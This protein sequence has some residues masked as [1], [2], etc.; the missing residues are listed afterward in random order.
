MLYFKN[1]ILKILFADL[2]LLVTRAQVAW[3]NNVAT[4]HA[5]TRQACHDYACGAATL[6]CRDTAC[7][8]TPSI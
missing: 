8:M 3:Q 7:G 6:L 2:T 4:P 5:T 1:N